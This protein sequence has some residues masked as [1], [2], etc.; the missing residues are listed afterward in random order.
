MLDPTIIHQPDGK[1]GFDT[2]QKPTYTDQYI[3]W[4]SDQPL[5]HKGATIT[6]LTRRATLFLSGPERQAREHSRI[7]E[8]L[9]INGYPP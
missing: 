7:E 5:H 8:V 3:P 4:D 1:L 2:Y 9:A 6:A